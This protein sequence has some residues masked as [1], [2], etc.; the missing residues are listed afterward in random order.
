MP[1]GKQLG[2]L[3]S[4][5]MIALI[6]ATPIYIFNKRSSIY[7]YDVTQNYMYD[8]AASNAVITQL[9]FSDGKLTLPGFEGSELSSFIKVN[10]SATFMGKYHEPSITLTSGQESFTQYFERGA[11]GVRYL[12][13]SPLVSPEGGEIAFEGKYISVEDQSVDLVVFKN[14]NISEARILVIAPHPDDAE[15][16]SYGLYSSNNNSYIVTVTAGEAGLHKYDEIFEDEVT[17]YLKKGK[18]RTWNSLTVPLL[19]G[20]PQE[21]I[22]NLGFF[23]GT[24]ATMYQD[25]STPVSG[26]FT[27]TKDINT[28]RQQ[29]VS[30][31]VAGLG[32]GSDWESLV[33]VFQHLL[34][35]IE[36]D[37]IVTPHPALDRH[38][39]HK[40]SS[41]ALFEAIKRTGLQEGQLY[42]YTNHFVLNEYYP[43]GKSGGAVSLPPNF[44]EEPYFESIYSHHLSADH[45]KDK[46]LA[47]EAMNDLRLDTEWTKSNGAFQTAFDNVERDVLGQEN[48]YYKRAVRSNELFFVTEISSL[49]NEEIYGKLLGSI[50]LP[51]PSQPAAS[52]SVALSAASRP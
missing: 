52:N 25:K 51:T 15:I 48:S 43:Y 4:M 22:I 47:L 17:H 42:L 21:Q 16:A 27:R 28:F 34:E 5:V 36:P 10:T 7:P 9:E 13:I 29:N 35:V 19:G 31:I 45:Q 32:G 37:V 40:F 14:R 49:Y 12:N 8:F 38:K 46:I 33:G 23:D 24:L 20:I 50:K 2:W 41:V 6:I 26:L 44:G 1:K 30:S 18:M 11:K 3:I 39:D